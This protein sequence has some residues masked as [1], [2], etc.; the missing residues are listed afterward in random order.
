MPR[1]LPNPYLTSGLGG[2]L[3]SILDIRQV[4]G[5]EL[6]EHGT[7]DASACH[8]TS[9]SINRNPAL[10]AD[11]HVTADDIEVLAHKRARTLEPPNFIGSD[12]LAA[13]AGS[14]IRSAGG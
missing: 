1:G 13:A 3:N 11:V 14:G 5:H 9:C 4:H 12:R 8:L 6:P 7:R 10:A 2:T